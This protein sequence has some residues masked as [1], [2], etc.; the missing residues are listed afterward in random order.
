[1]SASCAPQD[2]H[3]P[4]FLRVVSALSRTP[5][6][7]RP[8]RPSAPRMPAACPRPRSSACAHPAYGIRPRLA[9]VAASQCQRHRSLVNHCMLPPPWHVSW[10]P[11]AL[12]MALGKERVAEATMQPLVWTPPQQH[13]SKCPP[14]RS[15][16]FACPPAPLS[17]AAPAIVWL[18][19]WP[20]PPVPLLVCRRP[21]CLRRALGWRTKTA[22]GWSAGPGP[23]C[24]PR[25]PPAPWTRWNRCRQQGGPPVASVRRS[26]RCVAAR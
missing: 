6:H 22:S 17:P 5:A 1:M 3:P 7:L 8:G 20:H 25:H 18:R 15:C 14:T 21:F 26:R 23:Q 13:P 19:L 12:V 16:H 2:W 10:Q 4:Y 9:D 24:L 11:K